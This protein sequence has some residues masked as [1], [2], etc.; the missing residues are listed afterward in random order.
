MNLVDKEVIHKTFGKGNV[1]D[2]NDSYINIEFE[3]GAKRFVFP[4]AFEKY[5][6]LIDERAAGLIKEKIEQRQEER[7]EE[8]MRLERQRAEERERL[9]IL[10]EKKRIRSRRIHPS[11]QSVFW[12]KDGEE[13]QVFTE[14][15][16]FTGEIKSG[17]REGQ[18]RRLARMNQNSCC[19]LTKRDPDMQEGDRHILGVFMVDESFNGRRCEDGNIPAHPTYRIQLSDQ[20]SKK[21]LFWYYYVNKRFPHRMTWNSGRQRY[22][23]N[24]WM[25]QILRD[26]IDIRE[27]P[28]EKELAEKFFE[29]F[30]ELNRIDVEEL[31]EPNGALKRI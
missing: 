20:E 29:H 21:M 18:P 6:T 1:A 24:I 27:K 16:I 25:A 8:T 12:C 7:R 23:D 5:I 17:D 13:D 19:L 30:C 11:I 4:D 31:S 28:Q 15:S 22:F 9:R 10:E 2:Y 14:W 3:S 26:I